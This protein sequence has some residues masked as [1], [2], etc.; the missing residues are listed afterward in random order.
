MVSLP[1]H[2]GIANVADLHQHL[3]EILTEK[4]S[5]VVE[6]GAVEQ[7]DGAALQLL[8][9]FHQAVRISGT[10]LCW[11]NPSQALLDAADLLGLGSTMGFDT[12]STV[13]VD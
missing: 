1:T 7:I 6:A 2:P 9:S 3:N 13:S 11:R 5:V 10:D 8:A 4:V 12:S